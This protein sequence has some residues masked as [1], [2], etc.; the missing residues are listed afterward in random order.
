MDRNPDDIMI[1]NKELERS[2]FKLFSRCSKAMKDYGLVDDGDRI[3][4]GLSGGLDSLVLADMMS[5][6]AAIFKPS[7][8]VEAIH[9]GMRGIGYES[10][11]DYLRDFCRER[12]IV[13]H[14]KETEIPAG[15][16]KTKSPCFPCSWNRRKLLF[17]TAEERNCN[18]I[19]LGHHQDD[20]IKT[21][22]MN[23]VFQGA[24]ATMP[25]LLKMDKM[26]LSIIR[27]LC[28][29]TEA[30]IKHY[31]ALSGFKSQSKTCPHER[32]SNRDKMDA[33]FSQMQELN[34]EARHSIWG[35]MSNVQ[36]GYLPKTIDKQ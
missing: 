23:L 31:A 30:E 8:C 5:R 18:K 17:E 27:P 4:V 10:D 33:I 24:F 20:I 25:P 12:K 22:L 1:G 15:A 9:V 29:C 13:F 36:T 6:R 21:M 7:I 14:Y 32:E 19:A 28:T 26:P 16:G 34:P 2:R 11:T 35:A 3:L